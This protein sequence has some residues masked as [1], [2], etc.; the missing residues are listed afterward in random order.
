M[1][2]S[3]TNASADEAISHLR[4]LIRIP[5]VNPPGD[6][7]LA[8]GRDSTG[9]ETAAARYCA[10]VLTG[11]GIA[12]EVLETVPGRGSC[13]ARL[14]ADPAAE[15]TEPPLLL[16]SHLDVVP[17]EASA[18]TRDPFGGEVV[19]DVLWG[20]GAV[21]MKDM[22]A[23]ELAVMVGLHRSGLPLRRDVIFA[24]VADEEAGGSH[25]AQHW[26]DAR[27]DLFS[28]AAGPAAAALNE[29]GGYSMTVGDRRVYAIQVAEKGIIW[30]RLHATGTPGH[31]SMPH[32][33]N[34]AT[35]LA[36]AVARLDEA[37]PT[38]EPPPV[39]REFF[40]ALG[41][42]EVADLV[43]ADRAAARDRARAAGPRPHHAPLAG[44]HAPGH[45]HA[46]RHPGREQGERHPG[47]RERGGGR[48]DAAR[49]RSGV[50]RR[51]APGD[52]RRRR[53]GGGGH[54]PAGRGGAG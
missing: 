5:S 12:A 9:G 16:L 36:G 4:E 19:D 38:G 11:A 24:A 17:V 53:P 43:P 1:S 39:V 8:A 7:Q 51:A 15:C 28:S 20:R 10:E 54:E 41:L 31:G 29:V 47:H 25:G 34:A 37:P 27:P 13:F 32:A 48:P 18:W 23:M 35:R 6:P 3:A 22:V 49:H 50:V 30:T 14:T 42:G 40:A 52:C 46:D 26:V 21:D 33:E 45:D 44:R 2:E